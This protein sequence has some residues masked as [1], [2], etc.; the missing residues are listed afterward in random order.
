MLINKQ[1]LARA[2]IVARSL[3]Q[4]P[5][6]LVLHSFNSPEVEFLPVDVAA[7]VELALE[8]DIGRSSIVILSASQSLTSR[9]GAKLLATTGY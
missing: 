3:R 4:H 2:I 7:L 8:D 1:P 6:L 9:W 5:T